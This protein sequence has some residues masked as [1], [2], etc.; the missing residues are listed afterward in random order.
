MDVTEV[1]KL[2]NDYIDTLNGKTRK[3]I[4]YEFNELAERTDG[5]IIDG[6]KMGYLYAVLY[7]GMI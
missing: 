7:G 4:T 3:E 2:L 1:L 5:S 6:L